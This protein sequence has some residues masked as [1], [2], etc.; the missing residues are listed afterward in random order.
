MAYG[1]DLGKGKIEDKEALGGV[2]P[3]AGKPYQL[4]DLN[5]DLLVILSM[6]AENCVPV[7][8]IFRSTSHKTLPG[9]GAESQAFVIHRMLNLWL[10]N[11]DGWRLELAHEI[12][13]RQAVAAEARR[14][15][16]EDIAARLRGETPPAPTVQVGNGLTNGTA[17]NAGYTTERPTMAM[18]GDVWVST[19]V[20]T[21]LGQVHHHYTSSE[22]EDVTY[23]CNQGGILLDRWV[24]VGGEKLP[25]TEVEQEFNTTPPPLTPGDKLLGVMVEALTDRVVHHGL[26]ENND[27]VRYT[28]TK[29]GNLITREVTPKNP[30]AFAA[31]LTY[32]MTVPHM[33]DGTRWVGSFTDVSKGFTRHV[34]QSSNGEYS[35]L[36]TDK[37]GKQ[38]P[39]GHSIV[40][41]QDLE[42]LGIHPLQKVGVT[43]LDDINFVLP[44]FRSEDSYTRTVIDIA[45]GQ[46]IHLGICNGDQHVAYIC[47]THGVLKQR[48]TH[49]L[50]NVAFDD[51]QFTGIPKIIAEKFGLNQ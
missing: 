12:D 35:V 11:P 46:V 27:H 24:T 33:T 38:L 29:N 49:L 51:R 6:A 50:G 2:G 18:A 31:H 8:D 19:T 45:L 15:E 16:I 47:N 28:C 34:G 40:K 30:V 42:R 3:N 4:P 20:H 1:S 36:H 39:G 10:R 17:E 13:N 25:G 7:A 21:N 37:E 43:S 26:T 9:G 41:E 14:Q 32:D 22:G 48:L 44:P 23:I 5:G